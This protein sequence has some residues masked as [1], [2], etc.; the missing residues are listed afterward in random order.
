MESSLS[1]KHLIKID[2]QNTFLISFYFVYYKQKNKHLKTSCKMF[3]LHHWGKQNKFCKDFLQ[4]LNHLALYVSYDF[5][6]MLT[7]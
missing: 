7:K 4:K 2:T 3:T 5:S 6:K 1:I